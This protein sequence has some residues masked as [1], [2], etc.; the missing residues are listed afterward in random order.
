MTGT[1]DCRHPVTY[2]V[3]AADDIVYCS[4]DLED[5][6]SKGTLEWENAQAALLKQSGKAGI[7]KEALSL[8]RGH[9]RPARLQGKE[10]SKALA[11]AFRIAVISLMAIATRKTFKQNYHA[12]MNGEYHQELLMDPS[13]E[14]KPVVEAFKSVLRSE[15]YRHADILR[16]EVRGRRVIHDLLSLF[17]EGVSCYDKDRPPTPK[18]YGGKLYF[19]FSPNY[20]RHFESRLE[21]HENELYCR[22]QLVSDQVAGM[23]DTHASR[24]HKDLA[25]G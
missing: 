15:L 13:C 6:I 4:V 18:T 14:A 22:C 9:I 3:E 20:R 8:A 21:G 12:I 1:P 24:L 25:N 19:L 10:R 7:V 16:L 2:L 23:T 17:W 11:Q 5:G